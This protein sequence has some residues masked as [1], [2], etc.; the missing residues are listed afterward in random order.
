MSKNNTYNYLDYYC[1]VGAGASAIA[2]I[3]Q[4]NHHKIKYKVFEK[5]YNAGG[6]W[7]SDIL[8]SYSY[9][10]LTTNTPK[11]ATYIQ[12]YPHE[13]SVNY[14][15]PFEYVSKYLKAIIA[16]ECNKQDICYGIHIIEI[17]KKDK[18][19]LIRDQYNNLYYFR[20]VIICAGNQAIKNYNKLTSN[21]V[22]EVQQIHS[23]DYVGYNSI[24]GKNLIIIGSGQSA[25]DI[26]G[27]GLI[28]AKNI[29]HCTRK[30]PGWI[31]PDDTH[32]K[33][34]DDRKR[35]LS[36]ILSII[37]KFNKLLDYL[38]KI[39]IKVSYQLAPEFLL[40]FFSK[41][42]LRRKIKFTSTNLG[43]SK[44]NKE[45]SLNFYNISKDFFLS[46][47]NSG[48]VIKKKCIS[49][50]DGKNI[51]FDDGSVLKEIDLIIHATGYKQPFDFLNNKE[52][53]FHG[54]YNALEGLYFGFLSFTKNIFFVGHLYPL[55]SHWIIHEMQAKLIACCIKSGL[56]QA[57]LVDVFRKEKNLL[58]YT[59][60]NHG[61]DFSKYIHI[62]KYIKKGERYLKIINSKGSNISLKS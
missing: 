42:S 52:D 62:D 17:S 37:R 13:E 41:L 18:Y 50:I 33:T 39:V 40:V 10:G 5:Q 21:S 8:K 7:Q 25:I 29:I 11:T 31:V 9:E 57:Q 36:T 48:K 55:G 27:H 56:T 3:I 15:L 35:P 2:T 44:W 12:G 4:F 53:V 60:Y 28:H 22:D 6:V 16:K 46:Y 47:R 23:S 34:E 14:Y 51:V 30:I 54:K 61:K 49:K 59:V 26:I 24:K 45:F 19:W 20:G 1:I 32:I 38:K 58:A 43:F